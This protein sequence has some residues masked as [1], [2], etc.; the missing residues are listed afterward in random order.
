MQVI[1][2]KRLLISC[3]AGCKHSFVFLIEE[4]SVYMEE[5]DRLSTRKDGVPII[6]LPPLVG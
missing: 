4:G 6:T 5:V 3:T 2:E 1:E